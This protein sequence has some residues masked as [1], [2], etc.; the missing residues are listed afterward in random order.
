MGSDVLNQ[1]WFVLGQPWVHSSVAGMGIVAGRKDPHAGTLLFNTVFSDFD[2]D[3]FELTKDKA[4]ELV[5]H[6][7]YLHNCWLAE[8]KRID[9]LVYAMDEFA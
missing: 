2:P 1:E 5:Q 8:K 7:V 3:N 9:E 4:I 6:I